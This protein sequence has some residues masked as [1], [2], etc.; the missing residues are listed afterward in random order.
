[1]SLQYRFLVTATVGGRPLGGFQT[2]TGGETTAESVKD[3]PPGQE[4][5]ISLGGPKGIGNITVSRT[6]DP[7]RDDPALIAHLHG[8]VGRRDNSTIGKV[9]LDADMNPRGS[10][11]T[12][13]GTL[14]RFAPPEANSNSSDKGTI[15]LEFEI[16]GR[17]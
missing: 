2:F 3:R 9:P 10:G 1:M 5:E 4:Y 14:I 6:F 13:R 12:Y 7:D 8:Q 17:A 15:E 16:S 11:D